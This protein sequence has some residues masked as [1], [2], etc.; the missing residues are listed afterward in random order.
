MAYQTVIYEKKGNIAYVTL[1]RPEQLNAT[2]HALRE[3][4][5]QVWQEI[6]K[7]DEVRVV[8]LT[9][10]GRG[11]CSGA[12]MKDAAQSPEQDETQRLRRMYFPNPWEF[13]MD[14]AEFNKPMIGAVN[15]VCAGGGFRL[16]GGCDIIICSEK[17]EFLD[18]HVSVGYLPFFETMATLKRMPYGLAMR[19]ALMGTSERMSAQR[20][21]EVGF[22]S[23]VV[24]HDKLMERATE[25]AEVIAR[26][27]PLSVRYIKETINRAWGPPYEDA[28]EIGRQAMQLV[29]RD[30]EDGKEGPRA[31]AQKR[32]PQW[33]GR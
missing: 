22:V 28:R 24:P 2:N 7:D 31:F 12:D 26:Q 1:N 11:F 16:L 3:D 33:K 18:P 14:P 17:A 20:A 19:I 9:G 30:S 4:L 6:M 21:Y 5:Y 13:H 25:I 15:G 29:D 32:K 23:E 8:V 27:A 10:K